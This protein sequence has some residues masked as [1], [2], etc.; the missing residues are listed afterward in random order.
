MSLSI[1]VDSAQ[2]FWV[3]E[4]GMKLR[5]DDEPISLI[6]IDSDFTG[7]M[8]ILAIVPEHLDVAP[9][10]STVFEK[11]GD[12]VG[13]RKRKYAAFSMEPTDGDG[14]R[15]IGVECRVPTGYAPAVFESWRGILGLPD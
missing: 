6:A 3:F 11:R 2:Q 14:S 9:L 4:S 7:Y 10:K 12:L 15:K 8:K 5:Y 13:S 1:E